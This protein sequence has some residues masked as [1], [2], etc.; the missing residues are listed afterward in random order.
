MK[1]M[2]QRSLIRRNEFPE[3]LYVL[4]PSTFYAI[5]LFPGRIYRDS[6]YLL[7][8]MRVGESSDQWTAL[9]FRYLQ[10]TTI[11]GRYVFLN[12]ILG[13]LT[14]IFSFNFF[15]KS[16]NLNERT[17]KVVT[18][19]MCASPFVGLFGMTVGHDTT[20]AS[21]VLI[22]IGIL[23][24]LRKGVN[25]YL[26]RGILILGIFLC[27]TSFLGLASLIGFAI[28]AWA[29]RKRTISAV[30]IML[31]AVQIAFGS[32]IL[33]VSQARENL[34][35][36]SLLGDIKCIAQHPD[37]K[38]TPEQWTSIKNL[39]PESKWKSPKSCWIADNAYFALDSASKNPKDTATLWIHLALQN[40]QISMMAHIQRASVALPPIFFSPPPNMI[41]NNYSV[42]VGKGAE[43]DLQKFSELFKTSMDDSSSKEFRIPFQ[44]PFEYL[45]LF[46]AFVFNQHSSIWGWAGLWLLVF[47][48]LGRSMLGLKKRDLALM[49]TPLFT[50][51]LAMALV[52][53]APNPRYL[54]ATTILGISI[55][56][57]SV[58]SKFNQ[59]N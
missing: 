43:D 16:L 54:M 55:G 9:Y 3:A 22:L 23:V 51:H 36:T 52:S 39:A 53:P 32:L 42:P 35:M 48:S 20:T 37:A 19:V 25:F 57:C 24:R 1:N 2:N 40:P 7:E 45:A 11:N 13:L 44:A 17:R 31:I 29:I 41:E 38:I 21:G 56:L 33:N 28:A 14:L 18:R 5:A 46:I 6:T 49:S 12:A 59:T 58:M 15:M 47:I 4:I 8:L 27:S 34:A 10:A 30:V 26:N 50:M